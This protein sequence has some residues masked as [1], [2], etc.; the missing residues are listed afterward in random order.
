MRATLGQAPT[1]RPPIDEKP[2]S[3]LRSGASY[4]RIPLL[5]PELSWRFL[6]RGSDGPWLRGVAGARPWPG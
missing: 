3:K 6:C 1:M 2:L 4:Q 5:R